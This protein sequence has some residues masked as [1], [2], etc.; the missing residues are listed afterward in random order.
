MR[1]KIFFLRLHYNKKFFLNLAC[2]VIFVKII[3]FVVVVV[4][5]CFWYWSLFDQKQN[6]RKLEWWMW[7]KLRRLN[8]SES[9]FAID[10]K[11]WIRVMIQQWMELV[12]RLVHFI[13]NTTNITRNIMSTALLI[14]ECASATSAGDN[15]IDVDVDL[16]VL[17][18]VAFRQSRCLRL[19]C[20]FFNNNQLC[21]CV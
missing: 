21:V 1:K 4:F 7:K 10:M 11:R 14:N 19:V 17:F 12:F 13:E 2:S 9:K 5:C 3:L 6:E 15:L 16:F 20:F 18:P 8:E